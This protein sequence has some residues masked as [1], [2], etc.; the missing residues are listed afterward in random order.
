M[1]YLSTSQISLNSLSKDISSKLSNG[2]KKVLI[3]SPNNEDANRILNEL[4]EEERMRCEV[5]VYPP[6]KYFLHRSK[7]KLTRNLYLIDLY[8]IE[9]V[10]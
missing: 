8:R 3:L 7:I 1:D 5:K 9:S 2:T 10:P 6:E 4:R